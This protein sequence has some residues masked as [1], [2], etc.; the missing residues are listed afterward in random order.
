M[1]SFFREEEVKETA[2][3]QAKMREYKGVKIDEKLDNTMARLSRT[4]SEREEYVKRKNE[5]MDDHSRQKSFMLSEFDAE[6]T[7]IEDSF[8]FK[9][10]STRSRSRSRSRGLLRSASTNTYAINKSQYTSAQRS[11]SR[12]PPNKF[13]TPA[14]AEFNDTIDTTPKK[15]KVVRTTQSTTKKT[16]KTRSKCM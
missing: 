15:K 1:L 10:D 7:K 11:N 8:M 5:I 6:R 4:K 13:K 9:I 14:P 2:E 16:S 12:S 3:R